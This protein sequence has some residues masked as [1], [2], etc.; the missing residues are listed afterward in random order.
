MPLFKKTPSKQKTASAS[1][2]LSC[3][4]GYV[5]GATDKEAIEHIRAAA[6]EAW[7]TLSD[8][9]WFTHQSDAQGVWWC[10]VENNEPL[11]CLDS[12]I[13]FAAQENPPAT[14]R[15]PGRLRTGRLYL[16]YTP[17]FTG[18]LSTGEVESGEP[19]VEWVHD[20]RSL[21][22]PKERA[23]VTG[24]LYAVSVILLGLSAALWVQSVLSGRNSPTTYDSGLSDA[25]RGASNHLKA[26]P[27]EHIKKLIVTGEHWRVLYADPKTPAAKS[28]TAKPGS[29][30]SPGPMLPTANRKASPVVVGGRR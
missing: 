18:W 27:A 13:A 1:I 28:S 29:V 6:V 17:P 25:I 12:V 19:S 4:V 7:G 8:Q 20:G 21:A 3:M 2:P 22:P 11:S 16:R 10:V 24:L 30:K 23:W 15:I 26:K 5:P 9:L 14:V